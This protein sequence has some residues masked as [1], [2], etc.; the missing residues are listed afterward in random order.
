MECL[1]KTIFS[2]LSMYVDVEHKTWD[3]I[4]FYVMLAHNTI[5]QETTSFT[6]FRLVHGWEATTTPD[7][8]LSHHPGHDSDDD[9]AVISQRAK[10]AYQLAQF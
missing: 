8:M 10:E 1:N 5:A 7:A 4:L 9:T 6:P 2:M 3:T